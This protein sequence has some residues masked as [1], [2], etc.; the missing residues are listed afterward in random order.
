M[1]KIPSALILAALLGVLPMASA[2]AQSSRSFVSA[3]NGNDANDCSRPTPCRTLSAAHDKTAANGEITVL[4]PGGYGGLIITK[5]ISIVNDGVGEA[6][7]LVSGVGNSIT[8]DAG[9]DDAINL[10]GLTIQG[11]DNGGGGGIAFTGGKSLTIENCVIRNLSGYAIFFIPK[12]GVGKLT[13]SNTLIADN[14][15]GISVLS[16]GPVSVALNR[17][18][19]HNNFQWGFFINNANAV[20]VD[21]VATGNGYGLRA[22]EGAKVTVIRSVMSNNVNGVAVGGTAAIVRVGQ[23]ALTGNSAN[24]WVVQGMNGSAV[25]SYGDNYIDGNGQGDPAP[26]AIARK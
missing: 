11:I 10:R 1:I 25:Q 4:D 5:A 21:S 2:Q 7:M 22:I 24:G 17:V 20:V 9:P 12:T 26:P 13:V 8:I 6:S 14:Y 16:V 3:A 15:A 18:E 23:S 19:A